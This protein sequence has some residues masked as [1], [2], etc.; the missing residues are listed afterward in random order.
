MWIQV[1]L[2]PL[3]KSLDIFPTVKT[4]IHSYL[5]GVK[6]DHCVRCLGKH[7]GCW[8]RTSVV[9]SLVFASSPGTSLQ[10]Q[11]WTPMTNLG[12]FHVPT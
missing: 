7:K 6:Y 4:L 10:G 8:K 5:V 3:G 12:T 9:S 2:C 11:I 1:S